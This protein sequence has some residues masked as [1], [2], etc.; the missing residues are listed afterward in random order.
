MKLWHK[1]TR[2]RRRGSKCSELESP[3]PRAPVQSVGNHNSKSIVWLVSELDGNTS[4]IGENQPDVNQ[5][6]EEETKVDPSRHSY[7]AM[8]FV[9]EEQRRGGDNADERLLR[10]QELVR[11]GDKEEIQELRASL[12]QLR[13]DLRRSEEMAAAR[14]KVVEDEKAALEVALLAE[15]AKT[16][17]QQKT[18]HFLR[19]TN[20]EAQSLETELRDQ[21]ETLKIASGHGEGRFQTK[22]EKVRSGLAR[23]VEKDLRKQVATLEQSTGQQANE[24]RVLLAQLQVLQR[25]GEPHIDSVL[26]VGSTQGANATLSALGDSHP[27]CPRLRADFLSGWRTLTGLA[28]ERIFRITVPAGVGETHAGYVRS[29]GNVVQRFHG[30]SCRSTCNFIIDPKKASPCGLQACKLCNICL[31]GF[32]LGKASRRFGQGVYFSTKP[33]KANGY[34][35]GTEKKAEGRGKKLR[36]I[37]VADV[38]KGRSFITK[39]TGFDGGTYP[40]VGHDSVQAEVGKGLAFEELV[41]Y[42]EEAA[43]PTHLVVYSL[44]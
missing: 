3:L 39:D 44:P 30:T 27:D 7:G 24:I 34:A 18:M 19:E 10:K 22:E 1:A 14:L 4:R 29:H 20:I 32:K 5:E 33:A 11:A 28:I 36:C 40:P 23:L 13:D 12:L 15:R 16:A 2:W 17:R 41:V 9:A 6:E 31:R 21:V 43:L 37:I 38:A 8:G 42:K 26:T 25:N 35:Q